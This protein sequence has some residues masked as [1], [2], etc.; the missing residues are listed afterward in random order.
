M[1]RIAKLKGF[2]FPYL[3]DELQ[4]VAKAFQAI[5]TPDLFLFD[6]ERRLAYRGQFDGSRPGNKIPVTGSRTRNGDAV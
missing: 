5:C 6:R 1:T 2:A 3:Y 4:E